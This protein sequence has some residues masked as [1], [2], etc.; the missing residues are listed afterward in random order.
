MPLYR[1]FEAPDLP[2]GSLPPQL[3]ELYDGGLAIPD[4]R[5]YAN[6]VSSIDGIVALEGGTA[7]SGGIISG[8][9]EA[10]RLVM[11]LLRAFAEAVLVGAGTVR[12]E[13]GKALWTPDYIY[14][15]AAK[16][17]AD[18]RRALKREKVPRLVIVTG[19]GDLNPSERALEVGAL[20]L[21]TTASA[22]RLRAVLPPATEVRAISAA[23][24]I[25]VDDIFKALHADGY[26]TVLSEGGPQLFGQLVRNGRVDEL[27]L[28]VSPV[29]EGQSAQAFGLIRGVEF[30]R[31][32]KRSRLLSVRRHE[33][34]LFLRYELRSPPPDEGEGRSTNHPPPLAGNGR[35]GAS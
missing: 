28:T 20:V 9:N 7:P 12:A 15:A 6:F 31:A 26:R 3:A 19:S 32:P 18:L 29:L 10:D 2:P 27:F 1:L 13:G 33:S 34:H 14:P 8:R 5:T 21:T 11:G 17:F 30:G 22:K 23:D 25:D 35:V 4:G 24:P 16:A